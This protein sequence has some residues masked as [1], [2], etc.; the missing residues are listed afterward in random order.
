MSVQALHAVNENAAGARSTLEP[1]AERVP[2][3]LDAG[4]TPRSGAAAAVATAHG[5]SRQLRGRSLLLG[6]AAIAVAAAVAYYG[7]N[8]WT[9]GRF[10]VSTD[11]AYVKA[12]S[13]TVAPK[14]SGY[15][16][17]VLVSDNEVL[18][19][20][21]PLAHIDDRDFRTAL[22]QAT[23]DVA[24]AEAT[25]NAKQASLDIQQSTIAAAR[26]TLDVD[27]ANET[28]AEQNN[29]RYT[30]L[31]TNGYA[32]VQTAQQTASA[33]A[34]A[35]ATIVRDTA[36]LDA[37]IKQVDLL[38]AELTQA[39]AT[40]AHDQA[41]AHQAELNLSYATIVAPVYGTVGNRTLRVGQYVQ[42]G[43]QLMSV[44]PTTAAYIIANY[45]ETQL[46]DVHAGQP[47]NIDV[48]MFPG[49]IYRGHVDSIAPASGQEFALLPPDN[50]TGNFTKVVQRIPVK[51]VLDGRAADTADLRPGMSVQP[52]IDTKA[53]AIS[54]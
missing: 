33:I 32:P 20:G 43:T 54:H 1:A 10:E 49:R 50:A 53:D 16:S 3:T 44:V 24:A 48:D 2:T 35:Q 27:K 5:P 30:N 7:H 23:A 11:D 39:K 52:S 34:A 12:D 14:V 40:L 29:K 21:Q 25:V 18:K 4:K 19:A 13:T 51:I 45:K 9:E 42:A 41:V 37:A 6:A 26:A 31:A 36:A 15:L 47:V 17:E 38:N 8:Y 46:T 28:F 22:D